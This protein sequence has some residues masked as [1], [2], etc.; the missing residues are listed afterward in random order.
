[1]QQLKRKRKEEGKEE[2]ERGRERREGS[3]YTNQETIVWVSFPYNAVYIY[4]YISGLYHTKDK[5]YYPNI[6]W[7]K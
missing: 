5:V 7:P 6:V 2:K 1:M 3:E 4:I